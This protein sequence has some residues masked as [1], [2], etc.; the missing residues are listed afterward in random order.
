MY[1]PTRFA[2]TRCDRWLCLDH[3]E[4]HL[5]SRGR[6]Q[7]MGLPGRKPQHLPALTR[8]GVPEMD[9]SDSPSTMRTRASK[10]AV[11]SLSP[12]PAS[13]ANAVTVPPGHLDQR[14][15]HH[16]AGLVLDDVR[17][18]EHAHQL[19][20]GPLTGWL[21]GTPLLSGGGP[22]RLPTAPGASGSA[23]QGTTVTLPDGSGPS[24]E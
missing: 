1:G 5:E 6:L 13:K 12:S 2:H 22:G 8:Y 19:V 9:T 11:C 18:G 15:A 7:G 23:P 20:R 14:P 3:D 4:D 17:L 10:G 21:S 16:G 24:M